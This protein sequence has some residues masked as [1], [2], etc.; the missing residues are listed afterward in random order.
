MRSATLAAGLLLLATLGA[1]KAADDLAVE[2]VNA[3]K[4]T[5][6]AEED[7]VY[8]KFESPQAKRF[9]IE[10]AHPA[11]IGTIVVDRWA[12]DFTHC[13]MSNDPSFKFEKRRLTIYETE[14]W[15]LVGLT[16]PSFWRPNQVPVRVGNRVETGFH[17]LQLWT[18]HQERA[19][20]ILVLYPADGYWRARPL[21]PQNLRWSAYGSSF[22]VGPVEIDGRPFVDIK[23]IEFDPATRTLKTNFVRGGSASIRLD[24]LDQERIVLDVNL[25]APVGEKDRPFAG[26]RSMY[27]SEG[28]SDVSRVGWRAKNGKSVTQTPI[29]DF[30]RATAAE[31]WAGRTLP[32]KHNT[33]APD[34]I[35][36][37]FSSAGR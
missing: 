22:L 15:Q 37:D 4:P 5:L 21:P 27:V 20:E 33:S 24:K 25:S 26:L 11:Y 17:L 3:S 13:D 8:L 7:N 36:R 23:D 6:C 28:N 10:A 1:A 29:M 32:S 35:F 9:T 19:E 31:I 12:P 2:V 14:E 34:M 18:R 30:T 16:F